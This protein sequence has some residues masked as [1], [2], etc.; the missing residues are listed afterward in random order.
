[1]CLWT[2]SWHTAITQNDSS[3]TQGLPSSISYLLLYLSDLHNKTFTWHCHSYVR[4]K[5]QNIWIVWLNMVHTMGRRRCGLFKGTIMTLTQK[6]SKV[7]PLLSLYWLCITHLWH[8]SYRP[9]RWKSIFP[10]VLT[11]VKKIQTSQSQVLW[12]MTLQM[13][14]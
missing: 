12:Q 3:W 11:Y 8:S 1:M 14:D 2:Q 4:L 9:P 5:Y 10:P 7:S 13:Q 6:A